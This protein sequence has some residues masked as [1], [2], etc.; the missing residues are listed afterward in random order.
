MSKRLKRI[1]KAIGKNA[2]DA[3]LIRV[4]EG[5]NQNV[6]YLSGFG[7]S[8]AILLVTSE[9][10]YI[11]T[12]ARYYQRAQAEAKDFKLIKVVRG[13]KIV[14]LINSTL[15]SAGLSKKARVGFEAAHL[16]VQIA[17]IWKEHIRAKLVPTIHIVERFRQYK[18]KDEIE[19][20]R[21]ACRVTSRVYNEVAELLQ[22]GMTEN[23][24]AFE[25]DMRLRKYGAVSNSF[26]SIVASGPNSAVP[27]HATGE[28]KLKAGEP[29]VMDFGGLFPGG[30]CSDITRTAFIPGKKP[31]AKMQEIY[32]TVLA[33]NKA[34]RKALKPGMMYVDFDKIARDHISEA[35]YGKYFTHGLGHSLGLV[36]HDPY[37]YEHD[38]FEVGTV[39]TDEPGIYI[40]GF[41]GVR[42]E[43]DLVVTADGAERLT[44]APYWKF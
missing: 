35:G 18:D 24:V 37:D 33:A 19:M 4:N 22:P 7:G 38:P 26:T 12:D 14:D 20:L 36:A 27:H 40:D 39:V 30:Y 32:E 29:L 17:D 2:L 23:Q 25:L 44:T 11:I 31:N 5:D 43:D 34:A 42:I 21:H 8:T 10:A 9:R 41:G 15:S 28:R 16:P 6:L 13:Q 3:L 1:Q